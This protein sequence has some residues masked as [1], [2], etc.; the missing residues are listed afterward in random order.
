MLSGSTRSIV[1]LIRILVWETV[2]HNVFVSEIGSQSR[3]RGSSGRE[4][5]LLA[6]LEWLRRNLK[7]PLRNF[8]V[9]RRNRRP[10]ASFF[11]NRSQQ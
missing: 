4:Q 1:F 9:S 2:H 3:S 10:H 8:E 5:R 7:F 11:L 6:R